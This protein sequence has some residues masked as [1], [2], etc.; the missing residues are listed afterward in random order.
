MLVVVAPLS[1]YFGNTNEF[2][3]SLKDIVLPVAG[4]FLGLSLIHFFVLYFFR[5][6]TKISSILTGLFVGL[7]VAV[8]VQSQL[9]VWNF[10]LFRGE[11]I[12]WSNWTIHM[13]IEG[14]IWCLLIAIIVF[15][16][17]KKNRKLTNTILTG[18]YLAG[19]ISIVTGFISAPQ[20]KNKTI[21]IQDEELKEIFSFHSKNNVL[22]ILLD[23]FQSDFF[24]YIA[25][26]FP[27]E[28]NL[29]DGF[30]FY[31]NTAS[32]F[33]TTKTSL[34]S[35][36]S[37]SHYLNKNPFDSFI[38][39]SYARFNLI[40]AFK[41]KSYSSYLVG[42]NGTSP[43]VTSMQNIVDKLGEN[44][45]H[46]V[47]VYIDLALFRALPTCFKPFIYNNGIWLFSFLQRRNYPPD[48][49]GVDIRFL[50]L[51]EKAALVSADTA[52]TGSF[53]ILHFSIPHFPL[54]VDENLQYDPDLTGKEGYLK[55]ARGAIKVAERILI[56]LQK[57]GIYDN[58][59]IVILSDHGTMKIPQV[60][61]ENGQTDTLS[62]IPSNVQSS[63]HALLLHKPANSRGKIITDDSPLE[64]S[65]IGCMLGLR[66]GDSICNNYLIAKSG[67][68]RQRTF[69]FY[70]WDDTWESD[71]VPDMT[72]YYISGHVYKKSSYHMGRYI[73]T[74][75]GIIEIQTP[76]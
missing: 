53:K 51:F 73:Y 26:E 59:E 13:Y 1:F 64:I 63:S 39:E 37:G 75:N 54:C 69:Y 21:E 16:Y 22:L 27:E 11:M 46:P 61:Q 41:K 17:L 74:A 58:S 72:E 8:W 12:A 32:V 45:V 4:L 9:F 71:N 43:D 47:F 38:S 65:D 34:P 55:Q 66:D 57:L 33:P 20:N 7:A 6:S 62:L 68:T 56:T 36:I 52:T 29:F 15:I 3:F 18:I 19:L 40:D 76:D 24:E 2:A 60:N 31:R 49:A 44:S 50:E 70:N 10:G 5:R 25:N 30:T 42:F 48:N 14:A 35:I 67:G 28:V 23:T